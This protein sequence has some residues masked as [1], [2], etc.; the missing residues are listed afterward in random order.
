[1]KTVAFLIYIATLVCNGELYGNTVVPPP[2][3]PPKPSIEEFCDALR[4]AIRN[5]KKHED[6][7]EEYID[8]YCEYI[9]EEHKLD[10]QAYDDLKDFKHLV[11]HYKQYKKF[12]KKV[13]K[14]NQKAVTLTVQGKVFKEVFG[15]TPF[16]D[17]TDDEM[18]KRF[19]KT[20]DTSEASDADNARRLIQHGCTQIS[21]SQ[22]AST[23]NQ[24]ET[25]ISNSKCNIVKD[26]GPT[27][28]CWVCF[29]I[30]YI[31]IFEP[32]LRNITIC[33]LNIICRRLVCILFRYFILNISP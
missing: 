28:A 27:N 13:D 21:P 6:D 9:R 22:F 20:E 17:L 4:Y 3:T 33:I 10:I 15:D 16:S 2:P 23:N 24:R 11:K 30:I 32:I 12:Q 8:K 29:L 25:I 18:A 31:Y 14:M 7:D 19:P 1:M 5:K 26:Q